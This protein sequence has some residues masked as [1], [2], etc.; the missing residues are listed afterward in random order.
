M[1]TRKLFHPFK[2]CWNSFAIWCI[3][4]FFK[5][6]KGNRDLPV[7]SKFFISN[8]V[9]TMESKNLLFATVFLHSIKILDPKQS[10]NLMQLYLLSFINLSC[11]RMH[12]TSFCNSYGDL[13]MGQTYCTH[14]YAGK[15]ISNGLNGKKTEYLK[16]R[17]EVG[18]V[19]NPCTCERQWCT[20]CHPNC[21]ASDITK[22]GHVGIIWP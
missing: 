21:N 3:T 22:W 14:W 11:S 2:N 19:S 16:K 15:H 5:S 12:F 18:Q 10:F 6:V 1:P 20:V 8:F 7:S 9:I 4:Q 13:A 17:L